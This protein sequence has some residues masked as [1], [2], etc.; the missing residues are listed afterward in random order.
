MD[1]E[2]ARLKDGS[3]IAY[4]PEPIGEGA[5][6]TVYFTADRRQVIA[7]YRDGR[8]S[9]DEKRYQ[10]LEAITVKYNPTLDPNEGTIWAEYFCWPTGIGSQPSLGVIAPAFPGNYFFPAGSGPHA[11]RE[12]KGRWFVSPKPRSKLSKAERGDWLGYLKIAIRVARAVRRLHSAGLAHSDLS[13]NNVLIDPSRG[14][15]IIIDIDSLVVPG[16]HPPKVEGTPGYMAPEVV[17]GRERPSIRTDLHA[18]GVLIYEYLLKR[19]PLRGPKVHS[20]ESSEMDEALSMGERALFIEHPTDHSNRPNDIPISMDSLGAYIPDLFRKTFVDGLHS[21]EGRP[22][23]SDWERGLVRSTDLILPCPRE[24]CEGRWF[25]FNRGVRPI[26]PHCGSQYRSPV[27]LLQFYREGK[28]GDFRAEGHYLACWDGVHLCKWHLFDNVFPD[29]M[30][31]RK[32]QGYIRLHNGKW[33]LANKSGAPMQV[34]NGQAVPSE[35][36]IE[37]TDGLQIILSKAPHGRLA[38]VQMVGG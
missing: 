8:E 5:E 20:Q 31:D 6:K 32:S 11:G 38:V 29:Q 24:S 35:K 30:A 16:L 13:S 26:C 27:P 4:L 14:L 36:S 34:V 33:T 2:T 7:L 15:S 23:A 28:P 3:T 10:R 19:H 18:L 37:L 22:T 12:K 17:A 21:P 25:L 1:T 9:G